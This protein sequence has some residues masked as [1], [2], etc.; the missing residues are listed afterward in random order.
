MSTHA[1]PDINRTN[2]LHNGD[3]EVTVTA[4]PDDDRFAAYA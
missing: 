4:E 2:V 1:N 3:N